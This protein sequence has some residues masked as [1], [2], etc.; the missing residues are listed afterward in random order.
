MDPVAGLR[1]SLDDWAQITKLSTHREL[2]KASFLA[3]LKTSPELDKLSNWLLILTGATATLVISN[4]ESIT[5]I[6]SAFAVRSSLF[7]LILSGLAGFVAMALSLYTNIYV[8]VEKDINATFEAILGKHNKTE[9]EIQAVAGNLTDPPN[10]EI[11][12]N[13]I[14][15]EF[16]SPFPA[17]YRKKIFKAAAESSKDPLWGYKR[18]TKYFLAQG[19]AVFTQVI[20]F[21]S[22]V[23]SVA[24]VL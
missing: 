3:V 2:T 4:L 23:F 20:T 24:V 17:W 5:K 22:F 9:E 19:I 18:F 16:S 12:F 11:D 8:Q 6:T 21:L 1:K 15:Q 14:I 7:I 10:M 13:L